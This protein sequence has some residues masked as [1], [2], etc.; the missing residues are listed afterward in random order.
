MVPRQELG[1][2]APLS[3]SRAARAEEFPRRSF[4]AGASEYFCSC[5]ASEFRRG[6]TSKFCRAKL[7][8]MCGSRTPPPVAGGVAAAAGLTT[9][10]FDPPTRPDP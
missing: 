3:E 1:E 8:L 9:S 6:A 10:I 7:R 4:A 5:G 2:R